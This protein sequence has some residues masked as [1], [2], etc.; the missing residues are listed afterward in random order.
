MNENTPDQP[1]ESAKGNPVPTPATASL[2]VASAIPGTSDP[3]KSVQSIGE[4]KRELDSIF[5]ATEANRIAR[6]ASRTSNFLAFIGIVITTAVAIGGYVQNRE[7]N[8]VEASRVEI[9]WVST[10]FYLDVA[11]E[12][13][14]SSVEPWVEVRPR[15][16]FTWVT[17][18]FDEF[19][20]LET[21][22]FDA[23]EV[24]VGTKR[25]VY[26]DK[27]FTAS[28]E[29]V[30]PFHDL[31]FVSPQSTLTE[32][33]KV[34]VETLAPLNEVDSRVRA[35]SW[36]ALESKTDAGFQVKIGQRMSSNLAIRLLDE[37]HKRLQ[38]DGSK[39]QFNEEIDEQLR[40]AKRH[41]PDID[42]RRPRDEQ[43]ARWCY[44]LAQSM[45]SA[46]VAWS[47][48]ASAAK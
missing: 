24:V 27:R 18:D 38:D 44:E 2:Q 28:A 10:A 41:Y 36:T 35:V 47:A 25:R 20:K 11:H 21:E 48:Q 31:S 37:L 22:Y 40:L 29:V 26:Y 4:H 9:G 16:K 32:N 7:L 45:G 8:A 46:D 39:T 42:Y 13:I 14:V 12:K 33:F 30:A 1:A 3:T 43:R 17:L 34:K 15:G 6:A 5:V 23:N 19:S